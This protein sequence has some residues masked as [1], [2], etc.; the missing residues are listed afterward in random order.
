MKKISEEIL[1]A[2]NWIILKRLKL[3]AQ[4]GQI[5]EWEYIERINEQKGMVIISRLIPSNNIV[6]IK[7]YRPAINNYIIGFP[8]GIAASEDIEKEAL[9]ELEEET[10]FK[11]RITKVSP[12]LKSNPAL[13]ND[14]VYIVNAV[15]DE[16][17]APNQD[18]VQKL[19]TGE[20]IE[21][22]IVSEDNLFAFLDEQRK[23]GFEIGIGPWYV[24]A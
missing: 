3:T 17:S 12:I 18:P 5:V 10:G 21:V 13:M 14:D 4:D 2:G 8:A 16:T 24:F 22:L 20:D 11:G 23:S 7:Q 1:Y 19:S 9:R 15:I 6:M